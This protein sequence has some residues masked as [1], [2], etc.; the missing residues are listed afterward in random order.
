[1]PLDPSARRFL[2]ALAATNP[3]SARSLTVEERRRALR[4]LMGFF[5]PVEEVAR[6]EERTVPGAEDARNARVYTP[7]G[8]AAQPLPAMM[9]FHGGGLVAGSLDSHDAVC[10][11]LANASGCRVIALDYRLAPEHRFPAG[12]A[13]CFAATRWLCAH[14]QEWN[15]DP[16]RI[17]VG[18]D[19]AG[20]TLAAVI[21]QMAAQQPQMKLAAQ[22]L[23]CPITD[24]CAQTRSR[25][26]YGEGYLV[27]TATLEHDLMHYL[28]EGV[29]PA[30]PRVSPLRAPD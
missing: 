16:Q 1:M 10:R 8:A 2:G 30:D 12:I 4:N 23:L 5:G 17:I 21:C 14:A 29:D 11:S 26:D 22:F 27:D 9:F 15:I 6:V 19:S 7:L 25:R 24:F 28:P 13:D 20:A 18:G 3:P